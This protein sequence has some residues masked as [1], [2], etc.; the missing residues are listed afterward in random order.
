MAYPLKKDRAVIK[1]EVDGTDVSSRL[2]PHLLSVI[3]TDFEGSAMDTAQI[4]L[5]DSYGLLAVPPDNG[6]LEI[7]FGWKGGSTSNV[8]KGKIVDTSS[9]CQRR[10]GR[11]LV[12]EATGA[13]QT[14]DGK[15]Q[16]SKSW[17]EGQ[18]AEGEGKKI[19]LST[20]LEEAAKAAG[21][22]F[23][24]SEAIGNI[25]RDYWAQTNES[26][27][28]FADRM[29]REVG[30]VFKVQ[31]NEASITSSVENKNAGGESMTDIMC[32]WG[33]NLIAWNIHP[34][35]ARPQFKETAQMWFNDK[36]GKW[37][38]VKKAVG[39]GG[40]AGAMSQAI[41]Y[42]LFP[43]ATKDQAENAA[44]ADANASARNA[45]TGWVVIDGEPE[46]KGGGT[47]IVKGARSGV[48]DSYRITEA[49]HS[50]N[51]KSG[52]QTRL[53]L[54]LPGATMGGTVKPEF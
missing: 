31:G 45:G 50:W 32:A 30:G 48:D 22:Q 38:S 33:K 6:S 27:H 17:G 25:E 1:V 19:K 13:S 14:D 5:D 10:S 47:A 53:T 41:H 9:K 15:A 51:R 29:A 40:G 49:E 8:F 2:A 36:G 24:A 7:S 18:P 21:V 54:A 3:V 46:A 52:Y 28:N 39:L 4:E 12:I 20:V 16:V 26:F 37:E 43:H 44:Q 35:V 42:G 11:I 23:K 34:K